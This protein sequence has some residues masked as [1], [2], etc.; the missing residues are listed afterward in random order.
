MVKPRRLLA[1]YSVQI[2]I[3]KIEVGK[4]FFFICFQNEGNKGCE[5]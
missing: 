4:V 5:P 3:K 1:Y 2:R